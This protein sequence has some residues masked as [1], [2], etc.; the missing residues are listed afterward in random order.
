MP[1]Q[2]Q[3]CQLYTRIY[4]NVNYDSCKNYS[5]RYMRR[6]RAERYKPRKNTKECRQKDRVRNVS[7]TSVL[8]G[9]FE[10]RA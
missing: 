5:S 1:R 4:A 2:L 7:R 9:E 8:M 6:L 3:N 10:E